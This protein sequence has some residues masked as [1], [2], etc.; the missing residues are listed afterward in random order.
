MARHGHRRSHQLGGSGHALGKRKRK[1]SRFQEFEFRLLQQV[2]ERHGFIG[3]RGHAPGY[4]DAHAIPRGG[5]NALSQRSGMAQVGFRAQNDE[6]A[7]PVLLED[8][9]RPAGFFVDDLG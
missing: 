4:R 8:Q 7:V 1:R 5:L 2:R 6:A 9:I 3:K